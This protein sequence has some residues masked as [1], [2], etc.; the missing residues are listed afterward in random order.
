MYKDL[1]TL[2]ITK[3]N[4]TLCRRTLRYATRSRKKLVATV[5]RFENNDEVQLIICYPSLPAPTAMVEHFLGT[6]NKLTTRKIAR[7]YSLIFVLA[8]DYG[9][10]NNTY[11][12][13]AECNF[14]RTLTS[15][16]TSHTICKRDIGTT[17][18]KLV[19]WARTDIL[20]VPGCCC[21]S[22]RFIVDPTAYHGQVFFVIVL[23]LVIPSTLPYGLT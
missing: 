11:I 8:Y 9:Q 10:N 18:I 15:L 21:K 17:G 20:N 16:A 12:A 1:G 6:L 22:L 7:I 13:C 19:S 23:P 2:K 3:T 5:N 4:R 14:M